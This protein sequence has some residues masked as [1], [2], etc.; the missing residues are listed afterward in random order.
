MLNA[1]KIGKSR[2][3]DIVEMGLQKGILG[4]KDVPEEHRRGRKKDYLVAH[5]APKVT[6]GELVA[7]EPLGE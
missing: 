4:V 2:V 5:A 7:G 1:K 3:A 6:D